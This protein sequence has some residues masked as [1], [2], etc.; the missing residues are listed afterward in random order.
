MAECYAPLLDGEKSTEGLLD[1]GGHFAVGD[2]AN[3]LTNTLFFSRIAQT[4]FPESLH[5]L[6]I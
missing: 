3:G 6:V 2:A 1:R 5:Q 4:K